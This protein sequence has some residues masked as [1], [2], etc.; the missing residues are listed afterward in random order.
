MLPTPPFSSGQTLLWHG[1]YLA[2]VGFVLFLAP[3]LPRF[4]LPF[5]AEL[6]WWNRV[7]AL[8]LFNLGI[9]CI[10]AAQTQS[11]ALIKLSVAMRLWVMAALAA[12]ATLA[13]VRL[14]PPI[15]LAIGVVDLISATLTA[16]ALVAE[17]SSDQEAP[18]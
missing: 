7:L 14:V 3:G 8:P 11:R 17:R 13:A 4:F 15:A 1:V 12:V 18:N 9:L 2:A 10:G 16:W 5:S 6:D